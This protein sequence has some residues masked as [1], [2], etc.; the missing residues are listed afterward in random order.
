M[1]TSGVLERFFQ[2]VKLM[3]QLYEESIIIIPIFQV[4]NSVWKRFKKTLQMYLLCE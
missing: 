2:Y 4:E 3:Q 1:N